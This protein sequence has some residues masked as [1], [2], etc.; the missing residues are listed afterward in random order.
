MEAFEYF[1]LFICLFIFFGWIPILAIKSLV[2]GIIN[3]IK[4]HRCIHKLEYEEVPIQDSFSENPT[5]ISVSI[6]CRKCGYH[7]AYLKYE[8]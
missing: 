1:Y 4:N 3:T 6:T 8:N 7:K 5:N 2:C